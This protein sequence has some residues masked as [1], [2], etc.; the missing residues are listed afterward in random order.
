MIGILST[1]EIVEPF[2][3]E[4]ELPFPFGLV[5]ENNEE[6][7]NRETVCGRYLETKELKWC[8][9]SV[10]FCD[11]RPRKTTVRIF[12][13]NAGISLQTSKHSWTLGTLK[14]CFGQKVFDMSV[15]SYLESAL[16][17]NCRYVLWLLTL[18]S[19]ISQ[20]AFL[21]FKVFLCKMELVLSY[22]V[23]FIRNLI[24]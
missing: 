13:L 22:F 3:S 15:F 1:V 24:T 12:R 5:C 11:L 18:N 23:V 19:C 14:I 9:V 4:R 7:P 21:K 8:Q 2:E 6:F 16:D 20:N 10:A 17:W